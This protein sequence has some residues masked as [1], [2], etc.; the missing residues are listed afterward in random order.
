LASE[1]PLV[2]SIAAAYF[3]G[4]TAKR[5]QVSLRV[6]SG[7]LIVTGD[8]VARAVPLADV[9]TSEPLGTARRIVRLPGGASCEIDNH[10]AFALL[11][12]P[13][14]LGRR[15]VSRLETTWLWLAV[16]AVLLLLTLVG[17]YRYAIPAAAGSIAARLPAPLTDEIGRHVLATL[18]AQLFMPSA[19]PAS[20][21]TQLTEAF[22]RLEF[23]PQA[24]RPEYV[25]EF[26]R[27]DIV[28]ANA[29]ALP[30]RTV[31][32]TDALVELTKDDRELVA[33]LAHEAGHLAHRHGLRQLVQ[34]SLVG[35]LVAWFVGDAGTLLAAAP[36]A[37]LQA[38]YSRDLEYEADDYAAA[39]LRAN[40]IPASYMA[41]VLR[42]LDE[43][44]EV[45]G[46]SDVV[47]RYL[48]THPATAERLARLEAGS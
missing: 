8:E 23:A 13:E 29:F 24:E 20:R 43:A 2:G 7:Q 9:E 37:L 11:F 26:R 40:G 3:D 47:Q 5:H 31:V 48:S 4:R 15:V 17:A 10:D 25:L 28:G 18:D 42:R 1:T 30:S 27:S 35:F 16:A 14:R 19:L 22:R 33:V 21:R 44:S 34:N 6:D 41:D 12:G 38:R 39:T 36:T 32:M 45:E 46:T